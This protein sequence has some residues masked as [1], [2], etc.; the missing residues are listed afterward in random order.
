MDMLS[1]PEL[2]RPEPR[3]EIDEVPAKPLELGIGPGLVPEEVI[4]EGAVC[5][6]WKTEPPATNP[7]S[8]VVSPTAKPAPGSYI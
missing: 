8:H 4:V 7:V 2:Y 5:T 3:S 6:I 1:S